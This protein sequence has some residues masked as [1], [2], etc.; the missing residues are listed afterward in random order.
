MGFYAVEEDRTYGTKNRV[1]VE[2]DEDT[3]FPGTLPGV[4]GQCQDRLQVE[5]TLFARRHRGHGRRI[6]ASQNKS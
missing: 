1:C 3:Q 6:A 4:W 2:S 5:A